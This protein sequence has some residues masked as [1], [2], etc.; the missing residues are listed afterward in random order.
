[1]LMRAIQYILLGIYKVTYGLYI[2]KRYRLKLSPCS[3]SL[4][5][6]PYLL[7]ANHCNNFDGLFLQCLLSK[8]IHFVV[9]DSVFK[10]RALGGLMSLVGYIP[11]KKFVSD[12]KTIRQII[13]STR[14]GG[15]V[16][17]FPEGRR[18]WDGKTVHISK[19]TYKLIRMLKVP[20]VTAKIKGAYLSEPR[21]A[22]NKRY[23]TVE[24]ELKTLLDAESLSR[25]SLSEI[26]EKIMA[27]LEHN[28]FEWQKDKMIPFK[29]KGLAEGFERLLF[30]CPECKKYNTMDSSGERIWCT[31]LRCGVLSRLVRLYP[32]KKRIP[33]D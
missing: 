31:L 13:R 18:S 14:N 28:E 27:A 11:K 5:N 32:R 2:R 17:I 15:I 25:M 22:N 3:E 23:G 24:V 16:G 9:T 8:P 4:A 10:N 29:G 12:F 19:P 26:E 21:W 30:M 7:L 33:S 20:V 6:G 1:M